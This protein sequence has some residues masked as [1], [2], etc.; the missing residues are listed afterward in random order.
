LKKQ[1]WGECD[2]ELVTAAT[3]LHSNSE[4]GETGEPLGLQEARY[5]RAAEANG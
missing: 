2:D 3:Q 4:E 1:M 5:L